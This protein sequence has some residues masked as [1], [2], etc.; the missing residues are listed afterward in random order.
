MTA[1]DRRPGRAGMGRGR[2]AGNVHGVQ[3][4]YTLQHCVR[5]YMLLL[6]RSAIAI[7]Y[8][9]CCGAV[10]FGC[11]PPPRADMPLERDRN[12]AR[13]GFFRRMRAYRVI[14]LAQHAN[15]III[16]KKHTNVFE[17]VL[18]DDIII[19]ILFTRFYTKYRKTHFPKD[20]TMTRP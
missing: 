18:Y 7:C 1:A 19:I 12:R 20:N 17:K 3:R 14:R 8:A 6:S 10:A 11:P 5:P 15:T 16:S 2:A 4:P 9:S 13:E